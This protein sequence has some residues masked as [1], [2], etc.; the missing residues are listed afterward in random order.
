MRH[1]IFCLLFL[2]FSYNS[3]S[4][5]LI[6]EIGERQKNVKTLKARFSQ[7]KK[8][9]LL[10]RPMKSAG[11]FY[12]KSQRGVRWQYDEGLIVIFDGSSLYIYHP[13]M[14]AAEKIKDITGYVGPLNFDINFLKEEYVMEASKTGAF[15]TIELR[16]K[17]D[18]P[19]TSMKLLFPA[20]GV[21]P[22][23]VGIIEETG[24]KT[25]IVFSGVSLN[26]NLPDKL[27]IFTPPP[28]VKIRERT[29]AE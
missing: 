19:F 26:K 20:A 16:P 3:V 28:G 11:D 8:S 9:A 18:M 22:S 24:D 17:K 1:W 6:E 21:F 15:I 23:E 7:Q 27:F 10:G 29:I 4:A 25:E 14:E 5:G 2:A 12:F 13:E